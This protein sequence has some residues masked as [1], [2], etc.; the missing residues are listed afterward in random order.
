[1]RKLTVAYLFM[2]MVGA[3]MVLPTNAADTRI[4]TGK[5]WRTLPPEVKLFYIAG[6]RYGA[7]QGSLAAVIA[8]RRAHREQGQSD[9]V[10]IERKVSQALDGYFGSGVGIT[11]GQIVEL[12]D[13]VYGD[14]ANLLI[15]IADAYQITVKQIQGAPSE[16]IEEMIRDARRDA[17]QN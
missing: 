3:L 9:S 11:N 17:T 10:E 1:M 16:L 8:M 7:Q 5:M 6:Y 13:R 14:A 12:I 2:V 4:E 15:E